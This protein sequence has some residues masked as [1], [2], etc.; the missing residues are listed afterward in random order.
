MGFI[1]RLTFPSKKSYIG[2]T[3][4]DI[5]KRLEEHQYA[6]SSCVAVSNAIKKY[7]WEKVEKEW[8]E[9][10]D[11]DLNF[12]EEMLVALLGTLS[13]GGYNLKEGGGNG[14]S[15]E[16]TKKKLSNA[17]SGEKHPMYGMT[18]EKSHMYGKTLSEETKR[19]MSEAKSGEKHPM[20]GKEH[21]EETKQK[22]SDANFGKT[23]TEEAKQNMSE[24]K[25]GEKCYMFGK[26]HTEESKKKMSD[27]KSGRKHPM[28]GKKHT[29]ET[30]Q[31][32]SDAKLGKMLSDEHKKK[33]SKARTGEKNHASKR[34]YQYTLDGMYVDSFGSIEKAAQSLGKTNTSDISRCA[35]PNCKRKSAYGFKWSFTEL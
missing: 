27:A 1:Y 13:P 2:Q 33:L 4:R 15:S 29:E 10:P 3:I 17:K 21:T 30:K 23:H 6:S 22:M 14:K 5:H 20:Y 35:N 18:G 26:E 11:E 9:V 12:Y 31:K 16:E 32:M 34:V 25:F 28:Y 19:K 7:G 8:Y 24:A